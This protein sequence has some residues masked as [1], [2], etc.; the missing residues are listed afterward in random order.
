MLYKIRNGEIKFFHE[1]QKG[2]IVAEIFLENQ[3][4]SSTEHEALEEGLSK[5]VPILEGCL[6]IAQS[7]VLETDENGEV[8]IVEQPKEV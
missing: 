8:W 5:L 3:T 4:P 6:K 7:H 1:G 2:G